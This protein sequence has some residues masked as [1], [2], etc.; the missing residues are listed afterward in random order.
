MANPIRWG[1]ISTAG[2]AK[3]RVIPAIQGSTNGRVVAIASRNLE[4]AQAAAEE[5]NLPTAYGSYDELLADPTIDAIYNPLP[6]SEH[7]EWSIRCAEAGKPTLCEKP[8]ARNAAEA[9]QMVDAFASRGIPFAEAFMYRFHPKTRMA[10]SLVDDGRIGDI[11]MINSAFTFRISQENNIRLSN[12][13]AGGGLMDVGCYCVNLVRLMTG[14]EPIA[15]KAIAHFGEKSGV[16][17]ALVGLL[18]FPSGVLAHMDCGLRTYR[19]HYYEIR[20]TTGRI[21]VDD[22]FAHAPQPSKIQLWEGDRYEEIDIPVA[23]H[24]RL[25]A[26]DFADAI[27]NN[28]PPRFPAQD[29]VEN[30]RV[31][32]HLLAAAHD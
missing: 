31:I 15:I 16:D 8:L 4:K 17:E 30:M 3:K 32:E 18:R 11:Q 10:K 29:A 22:A 20:G 7:A 5:L 12:E 26:E 21:F 1:V 24:H 19:A 25:M 28:R 27:L 9:Q 23:D 14:E 6:N 2:I 13:L